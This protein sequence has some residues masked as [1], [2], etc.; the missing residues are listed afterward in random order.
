MASVI[1]FDP[2]HH[3]IEGES[4]QLKP[5]EEPE[6]PEL[7]QY[8]QSLKLMLALQSQLA[9]ISWVRAFVDHRPIGMSGIFGSRRV[10]V[11][12]SQSA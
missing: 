2:C 4:R 1:G 7:I 5:A 11:L 8:L 12:P 9:P 3:R 6:Q 10:P